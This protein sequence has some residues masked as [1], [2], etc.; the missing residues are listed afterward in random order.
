MRTFSLLC[1]H[2]DSIISEVSPIAYSD[3]TLESVVPAFQLEK[4][5][6]AGLFSE[7]EPVAPSA[8][9][10]TTLARKAPLAIAIGTEK[11]HSELIVADILIELLEYN[12]E[13]LSF[14][15]GLTSA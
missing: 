15:E 14:F 4:V 3:W 12:R 7:V 2:E 5:D 13:S 9:L 8:F 6:T 10:A 11:A 1:S